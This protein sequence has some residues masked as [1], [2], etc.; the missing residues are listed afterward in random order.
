METKWLLDNIYTSVSGEDFKRDFKEYKKEINTLN[1]WAR[2]AFKR[3]NNPVRILS[4]Y[5]LMKNR[6][7]TYEKLSMYVSLSLSVDTS[8]EE[9]TG[10]LDNIEELEAECAEHEAL[11]SAYLKDI[12]NID[13]L[14]EESP[15]LKEHSYFIKRAKEDSSHTLSVQE[16]MIISKMQN[17]GSSLWEKQWEQLTSNMEITFE[18]K[19]KTYNGP[20][21][22]VR[23]MAYS[24]DRDLRISAYKAELNAYESI[25]VPGAFCMNGIKGE[26]ITLSKLRGYSSPLGM[27]LWQSAVDEEILNAMWSAFKEELAE[28]IPY[29]KG[30]AELLGYKDKKLPFYELFAPVGKDKEYSLEKARDCVIDA[31]TSFSEEMGKFAE[32]AFSN[33]WIDLMPKKGK[34]GGAFCEAIHPIKESRILTNFGGT[35]N[36]VVTIAHE[37]GHAYHDSR[38]YDATPLNS[39]YPMPIAETAST[40]CETLLINHVLKTASDEEALVILE[41]DL[42]GIMQTLSDIYSR[43]LFEDTVFKRRGEGSLSADTLCDIMVK[44]QAE[45]YGD[46]LSREYMHSFMWLCKPHYYDAAFN[47]Y[48][49]PYAFGMLLSKAL[50]GRYEKEGKGFV[51]LYNKVL[52]ASATGDLAD[53]AKIAGF[54]LRDKAFWKDSLEV[55][56]KEVTDF[57]QKLKKR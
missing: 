44:A 36:D 37:L 38:L 7:L 41:N 21:S 40:F 52:Q 55:V 18:C 1:E 43:F 2:T 34:A 47:Y 45:A 56:K 16:E 42:S 48:N 4:E 50:Y 31:F 35:F 25:K 5:I 33:R 12:D 15:V 23:N 39:T 49:Y 51:P 11:F 46:T 54:D 26:V 19:G 32:N 57:I 17:T 13:E 8:N 10:V 24:A 14:I 27:T 28:L 22:S 3:E 30:K 53:V 29:F 6:L 9:L 20:L